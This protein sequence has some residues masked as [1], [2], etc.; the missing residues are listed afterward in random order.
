MDVD[1][2]LKSRVRFSGVSLKTISI[3]TLMVFTLC[4]S[5]YRLSY[6]RLFCECE[7]R[8]GVATF[9]D[10]VAHCCLVR[11]LKR[12]TCLRKWFL[13]CV[14]ELVVDGSFREVF[15]F[16]RH[17]IRLWQC[18]R[19]YRL[20]SLFASNFIGGKFEIGFEEI[21]YVRRQFYYFVYSQFRLIS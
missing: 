5:V 14:P 13:L 19:Y 17:V 11:Y 18:L 1:R 8:R 4:S 20:I 16:L 3:S 10:S 12:E 15:S 7:W 9:L 2:S 6:I 21:D